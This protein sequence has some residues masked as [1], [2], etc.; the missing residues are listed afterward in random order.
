MVSPR[1]SGRFG[2]DEEDEASEKPWVV[3]LEEIK[4]TPSNPFDAKL[5]EIKVDADPESLIPT[6]LTCVP[7]A[8]DP[9]VM[10]VI[11]KIVL[12]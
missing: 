9:T 12:H 7:K 10:E 4:L 8:I 11:L 6:A 2:L 3:T 5:V 1:I